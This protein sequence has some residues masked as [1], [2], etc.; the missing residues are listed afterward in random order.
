MKIQ[1]IHP[2]VYVH[3]GALTALRPAAPLG[4]AYIAAALRRAGHRVSL[5]DALAE[6]P[7]RVRPEGRLR[8]LGL[9]DE[10]I[11]ARIDPEARALAITNMWSFSWPLVRGM[12]RAIKEKHPEKIV[13]CG[14]EHFTGLTELSMQTAPIDY[15]A[16]GEGEEI[17]TRLF[18]ALDSGEPFDP[19]EIDGI[20]WRRG[21]EIV[22]NRRA[23]RIQAVDELPWPAWDLFDLD[24]YD[25][26][27]F[28]TGI[29]YGKTV[30]LLATRG[31][32][33]QCTYCSSPHMWARR[34]YP[35]DPLDV[36]NELQHYVEDYGAS[37]FPLQDLTA[38]IRRDW[39]V[40]FARELI[41]R[42]LDVRWQL[43]TGTRCEVVDDE[44]APLLWESGCRSLCFAP[45]SG[46]ERTRKLVKKRM[47]SESLMRSLR[48]SL[49]HGL[50]VT[51]FLVIGFPHDES[52]DLR[53]TAKMVRRL[54]RMGVHDIAC[55][56][57]FP[58]PGSEL[59]RDLFE[60]GRISLSDE[61]LMTPTFVHD[62][63]LSSDRNYCEKLS[64]VQLTL[65]KYW[66]VANFYLTSI[67]WHPGRVVRLMADLIRGREGSKMGTF[68]NE[69]RRKLLPGLSR[70]LRRARRRDDTSTSDRGSSRR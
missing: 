24:V 43:P 55:A 4:L 51:V 18:A 44:V 6:A 52:S 28:V 36:V 61:F 2:P 8:R 20:A 62:V 37:N 10:A 67:L 5:V 29:K 45:E 21:Q 16:M 57:F 49:D 65:H 35:R 23:R 59:Y 34:W 63:W 48:V 32:P 1:L 7:T 15:I 66:I 46:S 50:N 19:A 38:F 11:V 56:F 26:H 40:A 33:Y 47:K 3:P 30:P 25:A 42:G 58:I 54:A 69:T 53:E 22:I 60:S 14:G 12:I 39:V 13:V 17:A 31:C 41:E 27:N 70:T 64:A 68:L 9:A